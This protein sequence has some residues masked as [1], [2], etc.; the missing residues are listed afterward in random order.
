MSYGTEPKPYYVELGKR[1]KAAREY[2]HISTR[3]A[4]KKISG[5]HSQIVLMEQGKRKLQVHELVL[6]A[7]LY[8]VT[9]ESLIEGIEI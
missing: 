2:L 5:V 7:D 4:A 1:L 3:E 6:L 8:V 9:I